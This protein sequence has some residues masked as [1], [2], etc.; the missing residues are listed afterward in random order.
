M[1]TDQVSNK[2]MDNDKINKAIHSLVLKL[3]DKDVNAGRIA[4]CLTHHAT[5]LCFA[6]CDDKKVIFK[7]IL[8]AVLNS[9]PEGEDEFDKKLNDQITH[10]HENGLDN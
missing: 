6:A 3:L 5:R 1:N 8:G 2:K 10:H 7:T 9:M 4:A